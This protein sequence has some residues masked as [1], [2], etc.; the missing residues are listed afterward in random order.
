MSGNEA[1]ATQFEYVDSVARFFELQGEWDDLES[2]SGGHIFQNHRFIRSW[3][4]TV[5]SQDAVRLAIVLYRENGRLQAVFPGCVIKR[6][7]I[8]NL[9]WLGGF[10]LVDYGDVLFD[11]SADLSPH[12]FLDRAFLLFRKRIGVHACFLDHVREDA[13]IYGYLRDRFRAYRTGVAPYIT[14]NGSFEQYCESLKV[15]RK[16][17]KSDTQRQIRRLSLLGTLEFHICR[18]DDLRLHE[19]VR[20]FV[21]QKKARLAAQDRTGVIEQPGYDDLLFTEAKQNPH[22]HVSYLLLNDRIIAVHLGYLFKNDRMYYYMPSFADEYET[23]S[24]GR[25]L[26]YHLLE[27]CF[28][29][30]V[31]VFD[32]TLGDES[33]KYDWTRDET[34]TTSFMSDDLPTKAVRYLLP[35]R[36]P[37]KLAVR[38]R[39]AL[40]S[41]PPDPTRGAMLG[42]R[43]A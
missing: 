15:F 20:T 30:G 17:M 4:E 5:G 14:L 28:A 11:L 3:L 24:P 32:F 26:V 33:Y 37:R 16:K 39:A 27:H 6:M 38:V 36:N 12:D 2:R 42:S 22:T 43:V 40:S 41:Q 18:R 34:A 23:Y 19:V 7:G 10:R 8:A 29:K 13:V 9:T 1:R 35:L 31:K 21:E 25:V